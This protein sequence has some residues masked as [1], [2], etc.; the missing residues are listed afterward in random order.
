[1]VRGRETDDAGA[2]DN[3]VRSHEGAESTTGLSRLP[4]LDSVFALLAWLVTPS[5]HYRWYIV[6]LTLVNQ[7]MA[8]GIMIYSFALFVVPWLDEYEISR[9]TVMLAIL[10]FQIMTGLL[11]PFIGQLLDQYAMRQLVVFG[12]ACM[13]TGLFLLSQASEFWQVILVYTLVL[14]VSMLLTGTLASQTMISKWFTSHRSLAI[15]LSAMGTSIGGL[16][17]PLIT[18]ALIDRYAWEGALMVLALGSLVILIPLNFA[19]LR[20]EPPGQGEQQEGSIGPSQKVWG[21][22]EI[23]S[24]RAFWIPI[25]SLIPLNA[26]FGG[27]QF[28]LGAYMQ[29]LGY[30]QSTAAQLISLTAF[31]MII[32]KLFF[33]AMG[34]R[35]DHRML[36]WIMAVLQVCSLMLYEGSPDHVALM[37]AAALQGL[38]VGGVMPMMGIAYSAHFGTLSFGKILGYVNLFMMVGSFGSILSGWIFDLTGS[39]DAAFWILA[40]IVLPGII[41]TYFL[42]VV[43]E[44]PGEDRK[45]E[46]FAS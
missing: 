20:F 22:K 14:P 5:S 30:T 46:F 21:S 15:G 26:A 7:A 16:L 33:G 3:N 43:N 28:N 12:A 40:G 19:I 44:T 35:V 37:L 8:L 11:S 38:S 45:A 13:G 1:M 42:P 31:T 2:D 27:V 9:S 41:V 17:I 24:S 25:V 4:V 29:D 18:T 23:L 36:F 6:G 10:S 32:G 34:D 39:Y